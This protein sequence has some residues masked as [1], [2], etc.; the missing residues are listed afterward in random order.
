MRSR[1]LGKALGSKRLVS[2]NLK[3][4]RNENLFWFGSQTLRNMT[5]F[6]EEVRQEKVNKWLLVLLVSQVQSPCVTSGKSKN[7][8]MSY[9]FAKA[10]TAMKILAA[11]SISGLFRAILA[12]SRGTM[13]SGSSVWSIFANPWGFANPWSLST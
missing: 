5:C 9:L 6:P 3:T 10:I 12:L 2:T 1:V 7:V 11:L 8:R 4:Q 13:N